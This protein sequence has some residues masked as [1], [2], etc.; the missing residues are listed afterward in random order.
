MG[1][2]ADNKIMNQIIDGPAIPG[3]WENGTIVYIYKNKGDSGEC[4]NYRPI[5]L[6]QIIY[7]IWS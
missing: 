3:D 5:C 1:N 7:K 2:K 4:R 6:T